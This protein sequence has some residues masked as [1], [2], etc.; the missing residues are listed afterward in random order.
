[1][2]RI[3]GGAAAVF[4][5]LLL[6]SASGP[7]FGKEVNTGQDFTRPLTRADL[8]VKYQDLRGDDESWVYTLRADKPFALGGGW[9][10]ST[11][12]DV[13]FMATDVPGP[14]N[15]QGDRKR[16]L[17]DALFQG[18]VITAPEGKSACALG[19]QVIFPTA[20]EETLG[21]GK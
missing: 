10:F 9:E 6:S 14:D 15:P 4:G 8:R 7:V 19:A 20:S 12:A 3:K 18:L 21:T 2:A 11:R 1:M 5:M 17:S 13:P 16:G